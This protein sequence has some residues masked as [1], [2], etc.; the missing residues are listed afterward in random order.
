M[1]IHLVTTNL[2]H[3]TVGVAMKK[4]NS[5]AADPVQSH[6]SVMSTAKYV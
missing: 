6:Y 1:K 5:I 2:R 4:L 3:S